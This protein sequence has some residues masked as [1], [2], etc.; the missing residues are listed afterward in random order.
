MDNGQTLRT[1]IPPRL[2]LSARGASHIL[3]F[4]GVTNLGTRCTVH[5][6]GL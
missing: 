4:D 5:Q 6:I 1:D 2:S 3:N